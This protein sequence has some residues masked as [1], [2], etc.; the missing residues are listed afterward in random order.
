MTE[1]LKPL[2][3]SLLLIAGCSRGE[4]S[5]LTAAKL[6]QIQN[7]MTKQQVE[8]IIG[9]PGTTLMAFDS[10]EASVES[11]QWIEGEEDT[12]KSIVVN[13]EKGKVSMKAG[14]NLK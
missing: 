3:L 13:L 4:S 2:L 1:T 10:A 8:Q 7:G 12:T 6:E 9:K 14:S 11:L 5:F